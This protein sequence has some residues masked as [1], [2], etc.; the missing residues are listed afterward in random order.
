MPFQFEER[1]SAAGMH[2]LRI[3]AW[4]RVDLED[5]HALEARLLQPHLRGGKVLAVGHKG[6]EYTPQ[7]RKFFPTLHDKFNKLAVVVTSPIV[8]A[9]VNM[10]I[11]LGGQR[12]GGILRMFSSEQE[13]M[14]WLESDAP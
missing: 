2:Y 6:S 4:D 7:V 11:R 14:A 3:D 9:A 13:A 12:E 5:G 1:T 8:R 10:M